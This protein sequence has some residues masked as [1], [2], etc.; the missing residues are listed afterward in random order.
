MS[1]AACAE[2]QGRKGSDTQE[3]EPQAVLASGVPRRC[4]REAFRGRRQGQAGRAGAPGSHLVNQNT[5]LWF[6]LCGFT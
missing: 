4:L 6:V 5:L 3:R 2:R 1:D